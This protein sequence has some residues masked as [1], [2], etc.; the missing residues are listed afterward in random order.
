LQVRAES[1]RQLD[2]EK[3]ALLGQPALEIELVWPA[4]RGL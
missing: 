3:V 2:D 1:L 4:P